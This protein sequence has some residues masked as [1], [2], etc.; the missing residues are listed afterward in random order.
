MAAVTPLPLRCR[1]RPRLNSDSSS[2]GGRRRLTAN[3]DEDCWTIR[4][5]AR[6]SQGSRMRAAPDLQQ[7]WAECIWHS[8]TQMQHPPPPPPPAPRN[9]SRSRSPRRPRPACPSLPSAA[10]TTTM[11]PVAVDQRRH[12]YSHRCPPPV[13]AAAIWSTPR[14]R[15]RPRHHR[16]SFRCRPR[17]HRP[18][19]RRVSRRQQVQGALASAALY[20]AAKTAP[21]V[22]T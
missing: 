10:V 17:R 3:S 22:A 9:R 8:H 15:C 7:M 18:R 6:R 4:R 1:H 19:S 5:T 16:H 20:P 12:S 14:T 2:G 11:R 13:A 21:T